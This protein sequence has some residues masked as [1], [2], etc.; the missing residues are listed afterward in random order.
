[1]Y[2][3]AVY[4][5]YCIP[6]PIDIRIPDIAINSQ[7]ANQQSNGQGHKIMNIY[8]TD[9]QVKQL[10]LKAIVRKNKHNIMSSPQLDLLASPPVKRNKCVPIK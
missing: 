1:M 10:K 3:D 5:R 6:K 2:T 7:F 4:E 9:P 8:R